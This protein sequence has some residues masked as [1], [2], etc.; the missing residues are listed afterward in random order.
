MARRH[1]HWDDSLYA[2]A[3]A[4]L[5]E[6]FARQLRYPDE[7]LLALWITRGGG[8]TEEPAACKHPRGTTALLLPAL[9]LA[10]IGGGCWEWSAESGRYV[11]VMPCG[12]RITCED[13]ARRIAWSWCRENL[14]MEIAIALEDHERALLQE[15]NQRLGEPAEEA[16]RERR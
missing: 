12:T 14:G 15:R 7:P 1:E 6:R 5:E 11:P 9:D 13:D 2:E 10:T 8:L 4:W 16:A 3:E